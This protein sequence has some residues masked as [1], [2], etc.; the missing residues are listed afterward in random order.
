MMGK[1]PRIRFIKGK[2][3]ILAAVF[4]L[5]S[6]L[7]SVFV[8]VN[9][10]SDGN[11]S[12][13][14]LLKIGKTRAAINYTYIELE[15]ENAVTLIAPF[16]KYSDTEASGGAYVSTPEVD[17]A[18]GELSYVFNI[19][20]AGNY[21]ILA[22]VQGPDG[23]SDSFYVD[24]D[25]TGRKTWDVTPSTVWT[26]DKVMD[27]GISDP[28]IYNLT[29][30]QHI[31]KIASRES[32]AKLDKLIITDGLKAENETFVTIVTPK[33]ISD[34]N[35]PSVGIQNFFNTFQ[36]TMRKYSEQILVFNVGSG[37][38][39]YSYPPNA[40][41][42]FT[43]KFKP[44]LAVQT[45][46]AFDANKTSWSNCATKVLSTSSTIGNIVVPTPNP[47]PKSIQV[48]AKTNCYQVTKSNIFPA[49]GGISL[50]DYPVVTW[51]WKKSGGTTMVIQ[52][53]VRNKITG[54][55]RFIGYYVGDKLS[56]TTGVNYTD[57]AWAQFYLG[58]L[59]ANWRQETIDLLQDIY[60]LNYEDDRDA[61][62]PH[63]VEKSD[64]ELLGVALAPINNVGYY[65][66]I[67]SRQSNGVNWDRFCLS[68][69]C[70]SPIAKIASLKP[71]RQIGRSYPQELSYDQLR[72]IFAAYKTEALNRGFNNFK[73]VDGVEAGPE[74]SN[75]EW[76]YYRH[77]EAIVTLPPSPY[78]STSTSSSMPA[79][80][81]DVEGSLHADTK[82]KY[83]AYTSGIPEGTS[84][85]TFISK[86]IGKY[87]NDM[88]IDGIYSTND[89]GV[90]NQWR[91]Y[92]DCTQWDP[93]TGTVTGVSGC[94]GFSQEKADKFVNF[95]SL[96]RKEMGDTK[97]HVWM[98]TYFPQEV[99]YGYYNIPDKA[100]DLI[101]YLQISSF[102]Q[103]D[104]TSN[105]SNPDIGAWLWDEDYAFIDG[106]VKDK[107]ITMEQTIES[108]IKLKQ[109]HPKLRV[110]YTVY[111]NDPWY[112]AGGWKA[113][114]SLVGWNRYK[115]AVN[116]VFIYS[117]NEKGEQ[118]TKDWLA[119]F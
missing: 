118:I 50:H 69:T 60:V 26:W 7:F 112:Q 32:G 36:D 46:P 20:T 35:N 27:R 51:S 59:P 86:Q 93:L 30:G 63:E 10:V 66:G 104:F 44:L 25:G 85:S 4:V 107:K 77:P 105:T 91:P 80:V 64:W 65:G 74:F 76:K 97:I 54:V 109:L 15:A 43:P 12:V 9:L 114:T 84:V 5:V 68:S 119:P 57:K 113:N 53:L 99:N 52:F 56:D 16:Q 98:D 62:K 37:D 42:A 33:T 48:T 6:G 19:T 94:Q 55:S 13:L 17:V 45:L 58:S 49:N 47:Q 72:K 110:L 24:M 108:M 89:F 11:F 106:P 8:V 95:L 90:A 38:H 3:S 29:A 18:G 96:I 67:Y 88:K 81:I 23:N 111:F 34:F 73:I 39:I 100:Y 102:Y 92:A 61:K 28:V 87:V 115:N 82:Y 71:L 75:Q 1:L 31:L 41:A 14:K 70:T 83:A 40:F 2:T 116:G 21:I 79:Y 22:R 103:E 101:D 117:S 78:K